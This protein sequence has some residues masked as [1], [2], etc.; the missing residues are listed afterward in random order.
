MVV[1]A[2]PKVPL[3]SPER[4]PRSGSSW[5]LR[6]QVTRL[7]LR[8]RSLRAAGPNGFSSSVLLLVPRHVSSPPSLCSTRPSIQY[9]SPPSSFHDKTTAFFACFWVSLDPGPLQQ[10]LVPIL[11]LRFLI[12][13]F[14]SRHRD[15]ERASVVARGR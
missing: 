2:C 11:L 3:A 9:S 12:S 10:P 15:F 5:K 13:T 14:S 4:R 1:C 7:H 8:L 6:R